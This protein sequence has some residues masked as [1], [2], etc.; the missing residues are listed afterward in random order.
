MF[1]LCWSSHIV[2]TRLY[3]VASAQGCLHR[4]SLSLFW[5]CCADGHSLRPLLLSAC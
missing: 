4:L 5:L 2:Q 3:G 1:V